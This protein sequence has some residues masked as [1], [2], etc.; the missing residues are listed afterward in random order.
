MQTGTAGVGTMHSLHQ[1]SSEGVRGDSAARCCELEA[2]P[3]H[4]VLGVKGRAISPPTSA[5]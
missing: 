3:R 1:T 4:I 2:M 5:C